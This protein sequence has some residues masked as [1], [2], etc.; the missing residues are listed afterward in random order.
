MTAKVEIRE[1]KFS[2]INTLV[3][4]IREKDALE[5]TRMG[6][7]PRKALINCFK[8]AVI[9]KTILVNGN[10]AAM[11]GVVGQITSDTG[12]PYLVTGVHSEQISP[13]QFVRIYK[14]HIEEWSKIFPKMTGLVDFEY[15]EAVRL[16]K[17]A[18]FTIQSPIYLAPYEHLFS[19]FNYG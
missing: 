12:Y 6:F 14:Q 10:I 5:A 17:M 7:T 19:R 1:S 16:L 15:H 8:G 11:V 18:G 9:R 4:S 13:L 2:D 3:A